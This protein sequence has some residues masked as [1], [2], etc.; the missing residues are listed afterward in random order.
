MVVY[1]T[2][3]IYYFIRFSGF[4]RKKVEEM[5]SVPLSSTFDCSM[6]KCLAIISLKYIKIFRGY[7]DDLIGS[8][9]SEIDRKS[10]II[11]LKYIQIFR[12]YW[13]DLIG[14]MNSEIDR[15]SRRSLSTN[16]HSSSLEPLAMDTLVHTA[17]SP[18]PWRRLLCPSHPG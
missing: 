5:T 2:H 8:M 7:W 17:A 13:D 3:R 18:H 12:G 16:G 15:K 6:Q 14:S 9:N 4:K 1:L 11:S 10:S